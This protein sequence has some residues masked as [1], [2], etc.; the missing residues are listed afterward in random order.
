MFRHGKASL[1]GWQ[2]MSAPR[3]IDALGN[4]GQI[5]SSSLAEEIYP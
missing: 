5:R 1:A 2:L 3:P 4:L